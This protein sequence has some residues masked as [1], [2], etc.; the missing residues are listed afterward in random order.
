M[1]GAN[2]LREKNQNTKN[3]KRKYRQVKM[4][5]NK[6]QYSLGEIIKLVPKKQNFYYS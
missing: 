6:Y 5:K 3:E 2:N 1:T 4:M